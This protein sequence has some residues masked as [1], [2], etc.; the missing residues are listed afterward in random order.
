MLKKIRLTNLKKQVGKNNLTTPEMEKVKGGISY[1]WLLKYAKALCNDF[2]G[3]TGPSKAEL[4]Y[5]CED[6]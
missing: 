5:Y 3:V 1:Y 4:D 2:C 6:Y